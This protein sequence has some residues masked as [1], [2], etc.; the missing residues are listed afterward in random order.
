VKLCYVDES[1]DT[2]ALPTATSPIQPLIVI[3]AL[4]IDGNDWHDLTRDFIALKKQF[5]PG[6]LP[7]SRPWL[8]W[9]LREV[10]GAEVRRSICSTDR[11][12]MRHAIGFL[13]RTVNLL[14]KYDIKLFG[15]VWIK[16]IGQPINGSAIYTSSVQAICTTLQ[17]FLHKSP[18][19]GFVIAD[20][21]NQVLNVKVAHSIFTQKLKLGGDD[22]PPILE[23]PTFG[24][25]NNHAGLQLCDLI[26]SGLLFPMAAHAYC[27]G[28]VSNVHVRPQYAV[29]KMR[30]GAVLA[31]RQHRY[32]SGGR[33]RGGVTVDDRLGQRSGRLLFF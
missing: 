16:E 15:R 22:Y 26:C 14:E 18:D 32:F 24:H 10:K 30:Y 4:L 1:G 19:F 25:S 27:T 8:A 17:D 11:N 33:K 31:G 21:R 29:L 23:L 9:I 3:C 2:G 20:S 6:L 28:Y 5:F 12:E 13:D 7:P